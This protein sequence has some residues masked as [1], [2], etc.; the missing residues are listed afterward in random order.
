MAAD[1]HHVH[2]NVI[3]VQRKK[4]Q[5]VAGKFIAGDVLPS[6]IDQRA[7]RTGRRQ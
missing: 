7:L 6:E 4:V 1:I 2:C 3:I 5:E